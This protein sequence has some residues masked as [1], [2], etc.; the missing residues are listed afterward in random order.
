[1]RTFSGTWLERLSLCAFLC[2]NFQ[3]HGWKGW[4]CVLSHIQGRSYVDIN[5]PLVRWSRDANCKRKGVKNSLLAYRNFAMYCQD[6]EC[7]HYTMFTT[8]KLTV[9]QRCGKTPLQG[10][11][12][13]HTKPKNLWL[14]KLQQCSWWWAL[15]CPEHLERT[16]KK[17]SKKVRKCTLSWNK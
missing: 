12:N 5:L 15:W 8:L 3:E 11:R 14:H 17:L 10:A 7:Q 2:G 9:K 16:I 13:K 1:L 6:K 4:A